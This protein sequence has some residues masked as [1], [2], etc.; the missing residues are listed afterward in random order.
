[1]KSSFCE[2]RCLND[3]NSSSVET[4]VASLHIKEKTKTLE[5]EEVRSSIEEIS[6]VDTES[7]LKPLDH[8]EGTDSEK[9]VEVNHLSDKNF[10]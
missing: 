4:F 2:L 10:K 1:M 6:T 9:S 5:V 8:K 7:S 3:D